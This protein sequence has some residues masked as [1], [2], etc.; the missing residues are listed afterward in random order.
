MNIEINGQTFEITPEKQEELILQLWQMWLEQYASI[1]QGYRILAK[2]FTRQVLLDMEKKITKEQGKERAIAVCRPPK[3]GDPNLHLLWI[4][5]GFSR[6]A[7]KYA[8]ICIDTEETADTISNLS[9]RLKGEGEGGGSLAPGGDKRIGED[10]SSESSGHTP[11]SLIPN[12]Q[13]LHF[14]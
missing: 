7:M 4:L 2:P 1:G 12:E 11:G 3:G 13:T 14:R 8:T 9:F 10:D 5:A 6:E